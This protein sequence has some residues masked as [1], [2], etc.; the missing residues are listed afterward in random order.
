MKGRL[1]SVQN[2][3]TDFNSGFSVVET[4]YPVSLESIDEIAFISTNPIDH[5]NRDQH[6]EWKLLYVPELE[7]KDIHLKRSQA[8]NLALTIPYEY[9]PRMWD[10]GDGV[11]IVPR[12]SHPLNDIHRRQTFEILKTPL[13][14]NMP[15]VVTIPKQLRDNPGMIDTSGLRDQL[16]ETKWQIRLGNHVKLVLTFDHFVFTIYHLMEGRRRVQRMDEREK[17]WFVDHLE[18]VD[19]DDPSLIYNEEHIRLMLRAL[20]DSPQTPDR[21]V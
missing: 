19:Y 17:A 1:T 3:K 7:K 6:G 2:V 4:D 8:G 14:E 21:Y 16:C 10:L 20:L 5:T 15:V 9:S 11:F 18:Q 13:K 12:I